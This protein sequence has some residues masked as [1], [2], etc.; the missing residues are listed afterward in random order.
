MNM[1]GGE[2]PGIHTKKKN[3]WS[4]EHVTANVGRGSDEQQKPWKL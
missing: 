2:W 3:R 1:R 4:I